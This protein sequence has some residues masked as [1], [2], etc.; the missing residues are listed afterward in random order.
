MQC[1]AQCFPVVDAFCVQAVI[2]LAAQDL[3][4][5]NYIFNFEDSS[6]ECCIVS[7]AMSFVL[8]AALTTAGYAQLHSYNHGI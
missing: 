2:R 8:N 3:R 7:M 6:L 4:R 1:A 5:A